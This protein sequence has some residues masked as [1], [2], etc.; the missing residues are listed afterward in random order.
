MSLVYRFRLA[1]STICSLVPEVYQAIYDEYHQEL[2]KCPASPKE[3]KQVAQGF[4]NNWDFHN[5]VGAVDGK[6]VNIQ[7]PPIS[8]S[9]YY[10]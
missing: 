7:A 5:C 6:H 2:I 8:G 1:P 4:A 10:N 9:L 3:W